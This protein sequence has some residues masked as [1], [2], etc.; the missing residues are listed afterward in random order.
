MYIG[1]DNKLEGYDISDLT[2]PTLI[3]E[4]SFV[5]TE[6]EGT[7]S[8]IYQRDNRIY[9]IIPSKGIIVFDKDEDTHILTVATEILNLGESI[10]NI[11]S[12]DHRTVNYTANENNTTRL[13][14]YFFEDTFLDGESDSIYSGGD[15]PTEGCFIATA[16]YG[17]YFEPNV[18]VLRDFRDTVLLTNIVGKE[19]VELYYEY[20]PM[21]ARNIA[22][23]EVSKVV[24]R[25]ILTPIVYAIKYPLYSLLLILSILMF[26]IQFN[27]RK[28]VLL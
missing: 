28:G 12:M 2:S 1:V 15:A 8:S 27:K 10:D 23:S 24:V 17:S 4:E 18:K 16:S 21:I 9:L 13:K 6:Y 11:Y 19:F 7:P 20:S 22:N 14:I 3:V 25:V 26:R 5:G